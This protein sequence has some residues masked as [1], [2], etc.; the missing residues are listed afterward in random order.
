MHMRAIVSL[1]VQ[2]QNLLKILVFGILTDL[3]SS[4]SNH[5]LAPPLGYWIYSYN[6]RALLWQVATEK[7]DGTATQR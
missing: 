1:E 4:D 6:L 5:W 3:D 7:E 2:F